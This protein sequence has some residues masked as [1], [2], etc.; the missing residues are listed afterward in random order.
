VKRTIQKMKR[1]R[2]GARSGEGREGTGTDNDIRKR[3]ARGD[4]VKDTDV[5]GHVS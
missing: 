2:D 1:E 5:Q 4:G 3:S